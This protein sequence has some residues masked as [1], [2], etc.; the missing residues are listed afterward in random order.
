MTLTR[1]RLASA[2]VVAASISNPAS[3]RG[4]ATV[5]SEAA[6][7][8]RAIENETITRARRLHQR[9]V[10]AL[11]DRVT[12]SRAAGHLV[13]EAALLRRRGAAASLRPELLHAFAR[14]ERARFDADGD[15]SHLERSVEALRRGLGDALA[16][17]TLREAAMRF[18]LSLSLAHLERRADEIEAEQKFLEV[19]P[20]DSERSLV[21]ANLADAW[22]GLGRLED[23]LR[24][25]EAALALLP[26]I[27]FG[28]GSVTTLWGLAVALDRS[29]DLPRALERVAVARTYDPSDMHLRSP[30]WFYV[31]RYE[32]HWYAA[33]GSWH[34]GRTHADDAV[35]REA[36]GRAVASYRAY[37][38]AA[39]PMDRWREL[40][41]T[42][43]AQCESEAKKL[44]PR[45]RG[46]LVA[47]SSPR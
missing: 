16:R 34:V 5:W 36:Y 38:D 27:A 18:D 30:A 7:P 31:P 42:R 21:L 17:G 24:A 9:Y 4:D 13:E 19:E 35:R 47:P 22:M 1:H 25:Y 29:G 10:D 32:K 3:A 43:L 23:S 14:V 20:D 28:G 39:A 6:T 8:E 12:E 41:A 45:R 26:T 46:R 11:S 33:L 15:P 2:L 40:A 44:V 37:L